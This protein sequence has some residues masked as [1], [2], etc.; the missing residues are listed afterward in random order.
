MYTERDHTFVVC[1]YK[2]SAYLEA[3]IR[4][5][6]DQTVNG[7]IIVSTSTPNARIEGLCEKYGLP[8]VVNRG[9]S[10]I[11]KDWNFGYNAAETPLVTVAHQDDIYE[12]EFLER[13]LIAL[14]RV[15][16]K[17]VQIAFTDYC[18]LRAGKKVCRNKLLTIKRVL[19]LPL[20]IRSLGKFRF[21]KRRILSFG[22]PITGAEKDALIRVFEQQKIPLMLAEHDRMYANFI[23]QRLITA[24][25]SVNAQIPEAEE[26]TGAPIYQAV[27][28]VTP[29]EMK[30]LSSQFPN[31]RITWWT[32]MAV[33]VVPQNAGKVSGIRRYLEKEGIDISETMAFGDGENDIDMLRFVKL[34]V[35]MSNAAP[36][37]QAAADYVTTHI[38]EDG[39]ANAMK[40]F[41]II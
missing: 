22:N 30:A 18:E 21:V 25:T 19:L 11:A 37:V 6:L 10:S 16:G 24:Q 17:N 28:F 26:Y 23:N 1:A 34:G 36:H 8:L 39:I 41:S 3:A 7:R 38:D 29:E 12:P 35:A 5:L 9:E 2:E 4:S 40:H 32:E 15:E 31:C 33:D 13:S 14:N 27:A 20:R